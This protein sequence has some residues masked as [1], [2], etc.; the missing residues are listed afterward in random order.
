MKSQTVNIDGF[1]SICF[2]EQKNP[3][4][5]EKEKDPTMMGWLSWVRKKAKRPINSG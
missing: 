1:N 3:K 5:K 2:S 4:R